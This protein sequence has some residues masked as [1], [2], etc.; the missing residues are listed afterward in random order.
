MYIIGTSGHV[1]HGKSTLVKELT[2]VDVDRLPE[3]KKRKLT[4]ELGFASYTNTKDQVVGVIDVPGHERFI[5]NM[6]QG[7]WS[8]DLNLLVIAANESWQQQTFDHAKIV[9]AVEVPSTICVITKAD[10]VDQKELD[11]VILE[12]QEN[13]KEIFGYKAKIV[14]TN[15]LDPKSIENLKEV[16]EKTL[17]TTKLNTYPPALFIDRSF[18]L[19]GIGAVVTGS[20]RGTTLKINQEVT[21]LPENI[22]SKVRILQTFGKKVEVANEGSRT[23][24]ALQGINS[25]HLNKGS[26][27]TPDAS[28]FYVTDKTSFLVSPIIEDQQLELKNFG[29]YEVASDS[30]H[31]RAILKKIDNNVVTITTTKK[32]P[33]HWN[34]KLLII[35]PGSSKLLAKGTFVY[36]KPLSKEK[37]KSIPPIST[38]KNLNQLKLVLNG[39]VKREDVKVK[40]LNLNKVKFI[41]VGKFFINEK[42]SLA[43]KNK[44]STKVEQKGHLL[45]EEA[46]QFEDYPKELIGSL[47][48]RF[49]NQGEFVIKNAALEKATKAKENLSDQEKDLLEKIEQFNIKGFETKNVAKWEKPIIGKL[50]QNDY[51]L[52]LEGSLIYSKKTYH[53][54]VS[55]VLKNRE[56]NQLISIAEVRE[57][58]PL[59]RKHLLPILNQMEKDNL[60]RRI[61]DKRQILANQSDIF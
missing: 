35:H 17:T 40:E 28:Q 41:G 10:L 30:W 5:R 54:I 58:L 20:L 26:C 25:E 7:T 57:N 37:A 2:N 12:T 8:L 44:L 33:F 48:N 59:S 53:K 50:L 56:I 49:V 24:I 9:K 13:F 61:G 27:I 38:V 15:P 18:T 45:L 46:K 21:L 32:H 55:Q 34:Q 4:I 19:S 60:V 1:D 14:V 39:F 22:S 51:I 31:D 11:N 16:I 36:D 23:A 43:I 42:E 6:V 3:E 29:E 52:I 47:I